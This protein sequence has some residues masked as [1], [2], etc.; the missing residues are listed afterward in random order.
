MLAELRDHRRCMERKESQSNNGNHVRDDIR[1]MTAKLEGSTSPAQT[2]AAADPVLRPRQMLAELTALSASSYL[3]DKKRNDTNKDGHP[4]VLDAR[5]Q[6]LQLGTSSL[7]QA[8][9]ADRTSPPLPHLIPYI[10]A[11]HLE[12]T[13]PQWQL[14]LPWTYHLFNSNSVTATA[15][16]PAT[17][18][19]D[20]TQAHAQ[21]A[22]AEAQPSPLIASETAALLSARPADE[23]KADQLHRRRLIVDNL[24]AGANEEEVRRGFG[25]SRAH[26]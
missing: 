9:T 6:D 15:T 22:H 5:P 13:M 23:A 18:P 10:T 25:R 8:S 7:L 16:S 26:M 21:V 1:L 20:N 4:D 24:A 3:D 12:L 11:L 17:T 2:P 14:L 19:L